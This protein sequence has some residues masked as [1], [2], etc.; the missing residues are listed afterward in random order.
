MEALEIMKRHLGKPR[1]MKLKNPDGT[2]DELEIKPLPMDAFPEF[3]T[4]LEK[5]SSIDISG[6]K[7]DSRKLFKSMDKEGVQ[8]LSDLLVKMLENSYPMEEGA[9]E[10]EYKSI[11]KNFIVNNYFELMGV[12]FET[13]MPAPTNDTRIKKRLR[14]IKRGK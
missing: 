14:E 3:W 8:A 5:M 1:A 9:D 10:K 13:N 6:S 7:E 2:E 4:V 12:L 11:I